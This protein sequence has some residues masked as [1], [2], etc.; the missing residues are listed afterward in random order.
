MPWISN[1][2][3]SDIIVSITNN[4]GG[5]NAKYTIK[6]SSYYGQAAATAENS[7]QNFWTRSGPEIL[8]VTIGGKE[9][10]RLQVQKQDHVNIYA[11]AYEISNVT[12]GWF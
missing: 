3:A 6:P 5:N 4:S 11:D 8:T 12:W 1:R 9:K 10:T 7:G 2:T